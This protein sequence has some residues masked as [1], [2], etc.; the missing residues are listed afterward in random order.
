M[1]GAAGD[2]NRS[3]S[4]PFWPS[5]HQVL[6]LTPLAMTWGELILCDKLFSNR[7]APTPCHLM[8]TPAPYALGVSS[9]VSL[10]IDKYLKMYLRVPGWCSQLST[11][12][13]ILAQVMISVVGSSLTLGSVLSVE[14]A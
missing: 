12:L 10:C 3:A 5:L 1:L 2:G 9:K 8:S 7:L 6:H 11:Q 4:G 14:S 13:L